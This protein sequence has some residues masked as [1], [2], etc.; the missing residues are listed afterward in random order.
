MVNRWKDIQIPLGAAK[1]KNGSRRRTST[2]RERIDDNTRPCIPVGILHHTRPKTG[3]RTHKT[4]SVWGRTREASSKDE[5]CHPVL[6]RDNRWHPLFIPSAS[7]GTWISNCE[8]FGWWASDWTTR[9]YSV[10][11]YFLFRICIFFH[12]KH[13]GHIGLENRTIIFLI[14]LYVHLL[15]TCITAPQ[16]SSSNNPRCLYCS[17]KTA[18]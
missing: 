9:V 14:I 7:P 2:Q 11:Y 1:Q 13:C 12:L 18:T 16:L 17:N 8:A 3:Q 10:K 5:W 15:N 4:D 6:W